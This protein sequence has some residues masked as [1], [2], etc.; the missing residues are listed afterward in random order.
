MLWLDTTGGA[1]YVL[2]VRD[3]GNNHWLTLG[4]VTDPGAD[5]N[6]ELLPGKINLPSSGGIFESDGTT[7]IL[8]ESSGTVS[9]KNTV[10]D[11][12]VSMAASGLTVRNI[13]QVAL[14]SEQTVSDDSNLTTYF[15]PT[16]NPLFSGSKV[17]GTL[18]FMGYTKYNGGADG[19]KHFKIEF[20]GSGITDI[21]TGLNENLGHYD[22]GNSGMLHYY[23]F[24]LNGPLLT[25]S[26]TNQIT[27]NCKLK[28][29]LQDSNVSFNVFGNNT[30]QQ[31][32]MQWVEYK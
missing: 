24:S 9:L 19:R 30:L 7:E 11:S 22:Y 26:N 6:L 21:T 27:A 18:T 16:Y 3:A 15:S 2:K 17:Q 23:Y 10:I 25:T 20:T 28:N 29:N 12:T 4:N 14:A 31:T 32:F 1:P 8:T 13:T 5:G